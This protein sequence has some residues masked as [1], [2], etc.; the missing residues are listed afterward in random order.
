MTASTYFDIS[1]FNCHDG[2][3]VPSELEANVKALAK[4]L[5]VLREYLGVPVMVVS[6]YRTYDWNKKVGGKPKS[7]HLKAKAADIITKK[8]TPAQV[9][10]AIETL[11]GLGR[12]RQGGLGIYKGWV[13]YDIRGVKAR[14]DE[15]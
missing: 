15:R 10:K 14:W 12:M 9:Y 13:H 7:Q 1:E 3:E 11:I 2:T 5:D 8:F 4:E 6:G